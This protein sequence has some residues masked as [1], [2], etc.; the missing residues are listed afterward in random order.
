MQLKTPPMQQV[1]IALR[2]GLDQSTPAIEAD[3]G[4]LRDSIN[5]EVNTLGGYRRVDG[6]E[7][8][9]GRAL[10]NSYGYMCAQVAASI[11]IAAG[12]TMTGVTSGASAYII[13][14]DAQGF[15]YYVQQTAPFL[16]GESIRV[17][18]IPAGYIL[19][20]PYQRQDRSDSFGSICMA[21][22]ADQ[23]RP[24]ITAVPGAGPI[25][26]MCYY[27][28]S[29]YAFRNA[30]DNLTTGIYKATASGWS[31]VSLGTKVEFT[32]GGGTITDGQVL[33]KGGVT[34]TILRVVVRSGSLG[35]NTAAGTL[36][37]GTPSGG[38]FSS[39]AATT[40]GGTL[41]LSGAQ[42]AITHNPNGRFRF[43]IANFGSGSK[44]YWAS[45][46]DTA[47][48]FD[49]TVAVPIRSGMV[50]DRP[51]HLAFHKNH[52]FLS[53]DN[54]LQH[55]GIGNPYVWS[56]VLGAAELNMGETITNL[57]PKP[58][59]ASSGGAM[60]VS[61]RNAMFVLYGTSVA[62]WKL[63]T[64]Q[65]DVGSLAHTMQNIA[66][67]TYYLDDR[68]I[69]NL[70]QTLNFG[71]FASAT[72]SDKVKTWLMDRKANVIDSCVV[73]DKNQMRLFFA[74][75]TA[76]YLTFS[77]SQL[78]GCMP[79]QFADSVTHV[80]SVE[81]ADG[82]ERVYYGDDAGYV[83]VADNGPSFAGQ[84]ITAY[85]KLQFNHCKSPRVMKSFRK[86]TFE[87]GGVGFA[88]FQLGAELGYGTYDIPTQ[89]TETVD[90][91]FAGPRWDDPAMTWDST[92]WDGRVLLPVEV[93]LTGTEENISLT[94][95]QSS[96][97]YMGLNFQSAL[98]QFFT[99][100]VKR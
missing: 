65:K 45:G 91:Q 22:S 88:D 86:V 15:V 4:T 5:F 38:S 94:V 7:R 75:G 73:K 74:G 79:V 2:G 92:V 97:T 54:S 46:A 37:I 85:F 53:F 96:K 100:R 72:I 27:N 48:E 43:V 69:T 11:S 68:G 13:A 25:R 9:D 35:S 23:Y 66:S 98:L 63:V 64:Y 30:A 31:A 83:Y 6:Y 59:D 82:T 47:F 89:P 10:P 39:G 12:G 19:I 99:R 8:Y 42:S 78:T 61:T 26:G 40:P 44:M 80:H 36:I 32:A 1:Y 21:L 76:M 28:G 71:N 77:G 41:T 81:L 16:N 70:T 14:T 52:L 55:S 34:A 20:E 33:T 84:T 50:V 62:D 95:Y 49:G 24:A 87:V 56:A 60:I 58:S 90:V 18:G 17:N 67:D 29:L 57:L 93:S 51:T 3:P